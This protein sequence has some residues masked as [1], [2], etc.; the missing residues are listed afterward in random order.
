MAV[1]AK[2]VGR[3]KFNETLIQNCLVYVE[4][5]LQNEN[6]PEMRAAA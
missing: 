3:E 4:N 2:Y 1:F 6:D 5:T